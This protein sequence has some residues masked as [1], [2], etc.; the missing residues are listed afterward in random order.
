MELSKIFQIPHILTRKVDMAK[1]ARP[2]R[3][4]ARAALNC[5]DLTSLTGNEDENAIFELCDVAKHNRLYSVCIYPEHVE[6]ARRALK[7]SDIVIATV[8]NFPHG[9]KR[10]N[11]EEK[12]T[13]ES[14]KADVR[15]A[16][17]AGARQIDIVLA[18]DDFRAGDK[19]YPA[20][21]LKA[22]R[23]AC[24][25]DVTMKVILETASFTSSHTLHQACKLAIQH[26]ADCLKTSTGKHPSGG[27]DLIRAAILF[28]EAKSALRTVGVKISGGVKTV[29]DCAQYI[30]LARSIMGWNCIQ[31]QLFRIGGSSLMGPL[32]DTL[33]YEDGAELRQDILKPAPNVR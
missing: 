29:E 27:A 15:K 30:A 17:D 2:S 18:H 22:C 28:D 25:D 24:P 5:L 3:E 7:N 23:D 21:L 8:I 20:S 31:P 16:I 6:T 13:P 4:I 33:R 1:N 19:A 26:G 32:L 14:V 12:A 10:T 9:N 11:A